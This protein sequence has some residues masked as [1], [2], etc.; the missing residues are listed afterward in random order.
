MASLRTR[1][2]TPQ[3]GG[4][5]QLKGYYGDFYD[6]TRSPKRKEVP[7]GTRDKQA[8]RARLVDMERRYANG[9][10]DPWAPRRA[11]AQG[12]TFDE[13]VTRFLRSREIG[14]SKSGVATYR[15]VLRPFARSLAPGL[16]L[17]QTERR[18]VD[19]WL[20]SLDVA[21][22]TRASYGD[23]IGIFARWCSREGLAPAEFLP[24]PPKPRG[25]R[26]R[27]KP[28]PR[29]FTEDEL[30][31][32]LSVISARLVLSGKRA[33]RVDRQLPLI[34]PFG[35]G[36]GL[37]RGEVCALRWR[38]VH[39]SDG[40]SYVR[41][42]NTAD[43]I[44]KSGEERTVPLVG[45]AL[46]AVRARHDART[47]EDDSAFVFT[48][49]RGG[50]MSGHYLSKRFRLLVDQARLREA[51]QHNFH[52]LRHTFGTLAV[53]R[54]VDIYRV[55]EMMGHA[56]IETTLKY[57]RLR[58]AALADELERALG[59]GLA[60]ASTATSTVSVDNR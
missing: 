17:R 35:A 54:G 8:A 16:L 39:L 46:A 3:D 19:A 2:R 38:D 26:A 25:K 50:K 49:A 12:V 10:F 9:E 32:L 56:R 45:D 11:P 53:S 1:Y 34:I 6:P 47:N 21:A 48:G 42:A 59:G 29:F 37:R 27:I 58:P 18:H 15:S 7:L 14:G 20:A 23:R 41:V 55:K 44:T 24:A 30:Q 22:S 33:S 51:D 28:P 5:K 31:T 36:T 57:A 52:S 60:P 43:F 13:A 40:R 4:K